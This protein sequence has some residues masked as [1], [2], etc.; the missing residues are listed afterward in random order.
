MAGFHA[1]RMDHGVGL[2]HLPDFTHMVGFIHLLQSILHFLDKYGILT[3]HRNGTSGMITIK[4]IY[5]FEKCIYLCVWS[6]SSNSV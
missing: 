1:V 6:N 5:N 2:T 3:Y 4:N